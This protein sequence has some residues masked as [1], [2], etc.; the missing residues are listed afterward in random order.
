[1]I[2]LRM[3]AFGL[4]GPW[5]D[6]TGFAMTMEQVSGLAWM[7]GYSDGPPTTLHGPCDP[8]AGAHATVALLIALQHRRNTGQGSF[9]EAPMVAT[10]LNIAAEQ[11]IEYTGNKVLLERDGNRGPAA[12]PQNIYRSCDPADGDL[13]NNW[14]AIAVETDEQWKG[15]CSLMGDPEWARDS[16]FDN[17]AGRRRGQDE[18]D[19]WLTAW[20]GGQASRTV[21]DRLC[22][23]GVPAARV[24]PAWDLLA[25]EQLQARN[26][27]ERVAHPVTGENPCATYPITFSNGPDRMHRRPAPTLG[28]DN[29]YV[30]GDVLGYSQAG[31][32]DLERGGI[33]GT[34]LVS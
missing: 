7:S 20:I 23:A 12:A 1:V 17:S 24:T 15:L 13:R 30:F 26:F 21:A 16:R 28:Q 27:F 11:V 22:D 32:A 5:R 25:L 10:A 4:G 18:I 29:A 6:R 31:L 2:M 8:L 33:I 34:A 19:A 3:P 14:V 9:V